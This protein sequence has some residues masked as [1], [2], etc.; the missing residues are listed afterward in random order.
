MSMLGRF[1][2]ASAEGVQMLGDIAHLP[3]LRAL[4]QVHPPAG[5]AILCLLGALLCFGS[6]RLGYTGMPRRRWWLRY[7]GVWPLIP[8]GQVV[9]LIG[10]DVQVS[11]KDTV[12]TFPAEEA[13]AVQVEMVDEHGWV[14]WWHTDGNTGLSYLLTFEMRSEA[15]A[16]AIAQ[17]LALAGHRDGGGVGRM[18]DSRRDDRGSASPA[19]Q[20]GNLRGAGRAPARLPGLHGPEGG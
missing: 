2:L 5:T 16:R 4:A 20:R 7:T 17:A 9:E 3:G 11:R 15:E 12:L 10:R 6:A 13:G 8:M 14:D 18:A 1:L 19:P